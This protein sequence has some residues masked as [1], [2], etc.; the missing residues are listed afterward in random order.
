M[1][2]AA[3]GV[4][5]AGTPSS[6][7]LVALGLA[8][9]AVLLVRAGDAADM[10]RIWWTSST[11]A[12]CLLIPPIIA[13]LVSERIPALRALAPR[14]WPAALIAPAGG[15]VLLLLGDAAGAAVLRHLGLVAM[16][17]G[18]VP[19]L[20]GPRATRVLAFPL[21]YSLFLVPMGEELVPTLQLVTA[22][23]SMA[24]LAVAGV[25]AHLE[26]VFI[27]VPYGWFEVAEACS[28]VKFLV[29]MAA[30]AVLVAHLCFRS[31]TRRL[32]FIA[33]ALAVPVLANGL[34]AFGTILYARSAGVEAAT[35]FDHLVYGW[36]FFA[37]VIAIVLGAAW[38]FFD[39]S[40]L[41]RPTGTAGRG[42]FL[43]DNRSPAP[44]AAAIG[45]LALLP[46]VWLL[47]TGGSATVASLPQPDV[48]GW[49]RLAT[50]T[51]DWRPRY[52]GADGWGWASYRDP[53]GATVDVY[54][55]AYAGQEE[56]RE[57]VG[58]GQG[59]DPDWSWSGEGAPIEQGRADRFTKGP[60]GR[61]VLTFL[62]MGPATTGDPA[63]VK[64]E[65]LKARLLLR[66]SAGQALLVSAAAPGSPAASRP[67]IDRFL[68]DA[69]G[70]QAFLP[71]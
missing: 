35:G 20:L 16:L 10:A 3:L 71:R 8:W 65:T 68:A 43:R 31:P 30:L 14:V 54:T 61:E 29:A 34:R 2:A 26:G 7:H 69:G 13:W 21:A 50:P 33:F 63:R 4:R 23:L 1:T 67:A 45:A 17:A 32:L 58:F 11:Y 48:P 51:L 60:Q 52:Q 22:H 27:T 55:A 56:G 12:H 25:P 59:V 6:R 9:A 36:L 41:D 47:P 28:G 70:P 15:A 64:W 24:F 57:L 5:A 38:P 53:T 62:R 39:R 19:V 44:W 49:E 42:E 66:P 37:A 46:T 40:P 18:A